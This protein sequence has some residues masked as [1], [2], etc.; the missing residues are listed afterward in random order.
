M[1]VLRVFLSLVDTVF[2][3]QEFS[4]VFCD[5]EVFDSLEF[6]RPH[7]EFVKV[8]LLPPRSFQRSSSLFPLFVKCSYVR[9]RL[10]AGAIN[11]ESKSW[12]D[13]RTGSNGPGKHGQQWSDTKKE[14][15]A[16]AQWQGL[17]VWPRSELADWPSDSQSSVVARAASGW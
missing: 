15:T 17:D 8:F 4:S 2:D 14:R 10:V 6:L 1:A 12:Q 7:R 11:F 9:R 5:V 16:L 3:A 13:R